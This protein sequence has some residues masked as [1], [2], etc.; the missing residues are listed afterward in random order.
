MDLHFKYEKG[1]PPFIGVEF[2][3]NYAGKEKYPEL[4]D[5]HKTEYFTI[6]IERIA[7]I[8]NL[9]LSCDTK[10]TVYN[11]LTYDKK[12]FERFIK[13]KTPYYVFAHFCFY[14]GKP[15][16]VTTDK[17]NVFALRVKEIIML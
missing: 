12:L 15:H 4:A 17:G 9:R 7:G 5:D 11:S 16:R 3:S 14:H 2:V 1:K 8:I 13:L 10:L 6:S